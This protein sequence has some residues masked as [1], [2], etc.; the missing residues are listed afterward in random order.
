V[1]HNIRSHS[2]L[3]CLIFVVDII[4][5]T[6]ELFKRFPMATLS[7]QSVWKKNQFNCY[8]IIFYIKQNIIVH[9][10]VAVLLD[11]R[12]ITSLYFIC[13]KFNYINVIDYICCG[14]AA[15][16]LDN[17]P[18]ILHGFNAFLMFIVYT[19]SSDYILCYTIQ[20][21]EIQI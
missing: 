11:Y 14:V 12:C 19:I 3:H 8:D 21:L 10:I 18:P 1:L 9:H 7:K 5:V 2:L 20:F 4:F 15:L 6:S 17:L 16:W 13:H